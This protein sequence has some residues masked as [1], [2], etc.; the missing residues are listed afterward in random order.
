[1]LWAGED[2]PDTEEGQR[3]FW[4]KQDQ[5]RTWEDGLALGTVRREGWMGWPWGQEKG[6][7]FL[8]EGAAR[9]KTWQ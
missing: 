3:T 2:S 1:M 8:G 5:T 9:T 6:R 4:R 7:V